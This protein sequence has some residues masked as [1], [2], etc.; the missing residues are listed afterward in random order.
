LKYFYGILA[1]FLI[2]IIGSSVY[3]QANKKKARL[4][5]L[6]CQKEMVVFE[7]VYNAEALLH[8]KEA[9]KGGSLSIESSIK[10]A[11]YMKTKLFDYVDINEIDALLKETIAKHHNAK[12][13]KALHVKYYIYENDKKDPGKKSPKSKLYAGYI[14]MTFSVDEVK[15]YV[16]QV[17]FMDM[18]GKDIAKRLDC[19]I[20]TLLSAQ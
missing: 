20:A 1:I 13:D 4:S 2:Y 9:L 6:D 15:A 7:K 12:S 14:Y 19:A 10:K 5:R 11:K 8:V 17:D 3:D 16:T 18:Q